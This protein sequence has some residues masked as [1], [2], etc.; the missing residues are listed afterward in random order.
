MAVYR[1]GG[2]QPDVKGESNCG[3]S[4]WCAVL[5]KESQV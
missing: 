1:E 2:M 3:V 4:S 5:C